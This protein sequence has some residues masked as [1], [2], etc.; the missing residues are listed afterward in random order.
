MSGPFAPAGSQRARTGDVFLVDL[1]PVRGSEQGRRRPVIVFQSP[2]IAYTSTYLCV[3][4]TTS[5]TM[6]DRP[7][8]SFV[9]Q[10]EGGL[11]ED[12]LALGFQLR[13]L[14]GTRFVKRYGR[15]SMAAQ[16]RLADAVLRSLGIAVEP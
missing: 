14:D 1:E 15:L 8:T 9:P 12:S 5:M 13:A 16:E 7:G 10:G 3:P 4:V 6:K 2:D 11:P